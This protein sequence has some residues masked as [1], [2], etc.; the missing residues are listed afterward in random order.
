M[1]LTTLRANPPEGFF[2]RDK[3]GVYLGAVKVQVKNAGRYLARNVN[4]IV[5]LPGGKEA[6]LNGPL[7]V[8]GN[9]TA[10][11]AG[12]IKQYLKNAQPLRARVRCEN[13]R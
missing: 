8:A 3:K 2:M 9:A 12:E 6:P 10:L 13:C 7:T 11:Y 5:V 4:V 1:D